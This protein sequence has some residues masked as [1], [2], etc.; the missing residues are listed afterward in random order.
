MLAMLAADLLPAGLLVMAAVSA[1]ALT[2]RITAGGR[3]LLLAVAYAAL[4]V[5]LAVWG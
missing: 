1:L 5:V 4:A 3:R 2:D